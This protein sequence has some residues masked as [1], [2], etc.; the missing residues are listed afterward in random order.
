M[1]ER[2][3]KAYYDTLTQSLKPRA[4]A[5]IMRDVKDMIIGQLPERRHNVKNEPLESFS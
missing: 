4:A 2:M 5:C 1:G 3:S